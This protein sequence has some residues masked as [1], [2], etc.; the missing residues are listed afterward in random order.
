MTALIFLKFWK[1]FRFL[2]LVIFFHKYLS[3]FAQQME[4]TVS[5]LIMNQS[6]M[7]QL[8]TSDE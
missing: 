1:C 5:L 2:Q 4:A 6:L 7:F 3:I 8:C